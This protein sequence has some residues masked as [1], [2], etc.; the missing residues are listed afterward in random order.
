MTQLHKILSLIA[1]SLLMAATAALVRG[2]SGTTV[3]LTPGAPTGPQLQVNTTVTGYQFSAAVGMNA[4]GNS[5]IAWASERPDGNEAIFAQRYN[6]DGTPA[7]QEFRVD[8]P[9]FVPFLNNRKR[10][11]AAAMDA[12][13]DFVI[14]WAGGTLFFGDQFNFAFNTSEI[15]AQRFNADGTRL[16]PNFIVNAFT[17]GVQE[18]P[19]IGMYVSGE[20]VV[21]WTGF[22]DGSG[23]A[24]LSKRFDATGSP[25][26][27][28]NCF[29]FTG[30][31]AVCDF[32]VNSFTTSN[33][34]HPAVAVNPGECTIPPGVISGCVLADFVVAWQGNGS[35]DT[36]GIFARTFDG[37]NGVPRAAQFRV[38]TD[39]NNPEDDPLA[40]MGED[41]NFVVV[42]KRDGSGASRGIFAQRFGFGLGPCPPG[43]ICGSPFGP[44][45]NEFQ[46]APLTAG[47]SHFIKISL[48][49]A[50]AGNFVASWND[51][52]NATS[53]TDAIFARSFDATGTAQG[54]PF[55]VSDPFSSYFRPSAKM[56]GTGNFLTAFEGGN[57]GSF[58]GI[59]AKRFAAAPTTGG[60]F[61]FS[62]VSPLT[63]AAGA[64]ASTTVIVNPVNGF[65]SA[66][67]LSGSGQ[68]A[69]VTASLSPNLVTPSGGN[70]AS[71]VLKVSL[72]SFIVPTNFAL[73]VTGASGSL[74]HSTTANITVTTTTSSTSNF[75]DDLLNAGCIDNAGIANALT[76]KLS[77]A[78]AA[79]NIQTAIN[80]L[81]ALKNQ[82]Q[83]Q[84]GKHI[85]T[86][87]TIAGVAF[88][89][90]TAL[91]LDVQGLIDS[92]KVSLIPDP[93]TGY[94]VDANGAGVASATVSV[95]NSGGSTVA[96]AT[97]DITGFYFLATT[98]VLAPGANYTVAVTGVPAGFASSTPTNQAFTWQGAA[99]ALSN[100]VLN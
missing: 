10:Q 95:L 4:A 82:I 7:G 63:I 43:S 23:T 25:V 73:T 69:A 16:G 33:Q 88:N 66:V 5:V 72:P 3:V 84:A 9:T 49:M 97:S 19:A 50:P 56:D 20:F 12:S 44:L 77:A 36:A 15:Y 22:G 60:D 37:S 30:Q 68:P 42:W 67:N 78:Q 58:F 96:L 1:M 27:L 18:Q 99:I 8:D 81:T 57:D 76:S 64:T 85:D 11:P 53:A 14:V 21:A 93:V 79:G 87:C 65:S 83:A 41:G 92:L 17:A 45:G 91:F 32:V 90:V 39:T 35:D 2:Q 51:L 28:R 71:S 47:T 54:E 29:D 13:G 6:P 89:P 40:S 31:P 100:F 48:G 24:I 70:P 61:N 59:F 38:N 80:I 62:A 55:R 52:E 94:V 86:A 98:G 26:G 34:F 74:T 46:I 75:I